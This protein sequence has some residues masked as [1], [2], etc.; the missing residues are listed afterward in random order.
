MKSIELGIKQQGLGKRLSNLYNYPFVMDDMPCTSME[1]FIQ[2][3]KFKTLE[4]Q[5][6][7]ATME[8]SFEAFKVGQERGNVWKEDQTVYWLEDPI[9]RNSKQ[10]KDLMERAYNECYEQNPA[11]REALLES[12]FSLFTHYIGKHDQ[13]DTLLTV[14]EY[15]YNMYRLRAR[16][17]QEA[18]KEE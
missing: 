12:E 9:K 17:F 14:S 1:T 2:C 15:L 6:E 3:L 11:F 18:L 16:A 13:Q 4:E 10:Y 5:F 7:I 8:K